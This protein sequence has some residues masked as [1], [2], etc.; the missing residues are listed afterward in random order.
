MGHADVEMTMHY[1]H[2]DLERRRTAIETIAEKLAGNKVEN[3]AGSEKP[4]I[5]T[6][7]DTNEEGLET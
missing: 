4:A 1:T 7:N 5:L 2:S 3:G 6:L